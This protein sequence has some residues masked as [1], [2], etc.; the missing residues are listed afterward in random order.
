[1][2][3]L[4]PLKVGNETILVEAVAGQTVASVNPPTDK[5]EDSLGALTAIGKAMK[6]AL[7]GVGAKE[8]EV[9]LGIKFS[10][11]GSIIVSEATAEASMEVK[12][13]F[14]P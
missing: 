1:M 12:L 4:L 10:A 9:T 5:L 3:Q 14:E 2:A 13:T 8:A 6:G 7:K 11:T